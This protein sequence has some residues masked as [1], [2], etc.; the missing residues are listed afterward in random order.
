MSKIDFNDG[1]AKT[2]RIVI[3]AEVEA[4]LRGQKKSRGSSM[5]A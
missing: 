3:Y 5:G 2:D 4:A 1:K